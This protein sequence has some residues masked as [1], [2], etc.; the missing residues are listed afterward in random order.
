MTRKYGSYYLE[1]YSCTQVG[2]KKFSILKSTFTTFGH[3]VLQS[4]EN[5]THS[6]PLYHVYTRKIIS[7]QLSRLSVIIH[8]L[9]KTHT[10]HRRSQNLPFYFR[11]FVAA[12]PAPAAETETT[13]VA[14][15]LVETQL[16]SAGR[17]W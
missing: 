14:L 11:N 2:T 4:R 1:L 9:F 12:A 3:H 10:N 17:H 15:L 6:Y 8:D 5:C 13:S 16:P 7:N